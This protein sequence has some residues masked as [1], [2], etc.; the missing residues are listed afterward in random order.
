[1]L[2]D[3]GHQIVP[4]G[5][6]KGE[7]FNEQILNIRQKPDIQNVDTVTMYIGP[8]HQPEYY[9]YI[10]GLK[11]KRVIFNPGTE[12]QEFEQLLESQGIEVE[13]A[14]TLVLLRTAQY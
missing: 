1:M 6:K 10:A 9:D 12:N 5:I 2:K 8:N 3:H 14:C 11:P 13:E 7:I 4:V